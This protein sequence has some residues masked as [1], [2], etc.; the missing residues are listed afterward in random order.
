MTPG[1]HE[2]YNDFEDVKKRF[3]MPNKHLTENLYYSYD[4]GNTH[5]ISLNSEVS[6]MKFTEEYISN[7]FNWIKKDLEESEKKWKIVAIHR[8]LYCSSNSSHCKKSADVMKEFY[9]EIFYNG[10]VDLVLTGHLHAYERLS[11]I[12]KNEIDHEC[13]NLDKSLY[14]N[15]RFPTYVICGTGGNHEHHTMKSNY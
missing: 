3:L 13:V 1:N 6:F 7:Y 5:F 2:A 9:E 11:P 8:P 10:K 4:I 12:Y 14:L 15:P